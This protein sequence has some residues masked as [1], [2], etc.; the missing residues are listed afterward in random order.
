[1]G[2]NRRLTMKVIVRWKPIDEIESNIDTLREL[3]HLP[4]P[5]IT[6]LKSLQ[7]ERLKVCP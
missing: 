1:V 4:R 7:A 2:L 5:K 3:L 6:F